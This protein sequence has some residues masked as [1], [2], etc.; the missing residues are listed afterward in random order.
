MIR[1]LRARLFVGMTVVIVLAGC[2]GATFAYFW[3]FDEA[4]EMQDS[5]LLQIASLVRGGG[6]DSGQPLRGVDEDAEVVIIEL[7][8]AP[9]GSAEDRQLFS[10]QDGLRLA[11]AQGQS[12]PGL[13]AAPDAGGPV[14]A[15]AC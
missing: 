2:A 10:L 11:F 14:G 6:F 9:H 1:S 7:G 13:L 12:V 4:I 15:G 3:A 5:I 8:T